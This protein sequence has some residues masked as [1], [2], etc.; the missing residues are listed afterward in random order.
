[1]SEPQA[2]TLPADAPQDVRDF[3]DC[4]G[5][6]LVWRSGP[7]TW[8]G[9]GIDPDVT[10]EHGATPGSVNITVTIGSPPFGLSFTLPASVNADGELTV[11]TSQVPDLSGVS[12]N[13]P[14]RQSVDEAVRNI[15]EWFKKNGKKLKPA[16]LRGGA[17]TLEKIP[18]T[19]AAA[20]VVV[21]VVPVAPGPTPTSATPPPADGS[22]EA[23]KTGGWCSLLGMLMVLL[24]VG[25]IGLGG[26]IGFVFF[27]GEPLPTPTPIAAATATPEPSPAPTEPPTPTPTPGTTPTTSPTATPTTVQTPT[28]TPGATDPA[29]SPPTST[30]IAA[31]CVR[32]EH[33]ALGDYLSYLDWFLWWFGPGVDYFELV[34]LE[35]ND[36][37]PTRLEFDPANGAW[38]GQLGLRGTGVKTIVSLVAH[39]TDGSTVDVTEQMIDAFGGDEV[40]V[41][42]PQEDSYGDCP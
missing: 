25:A 41:H 10:F 11:D 27:G 35:A 39:Q 21:P 32:V 37:Q 19:A 22:T 13:A 38:Y 26:G 42:F 5:D 7:V 15:N 2:P 6:R 40:L 20:T 4:R 3:F 33:T 30:G 8:L 23:P 17:V 36:G 12:E 9:L 28:L 24:L 16:E 14:G 1:M 34:V 18:I 31:F 29:T